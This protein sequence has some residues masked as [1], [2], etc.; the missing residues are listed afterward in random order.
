M[1]M[2]NKVYQ[3]IFNEFA[4]YLPNDWQ[5]MVVYLEYGDDSYTFSFYVLIDGKFI[6]CYDIPGISEE[7]LIISYNKIDKMIPQIRNKEFGEWS[8]MTMVVDKEGN[9]K[10]DFDYTD[11][12]EGAYQYKKEWKKKYLE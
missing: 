11:L 8:N 9:M 2:N 6:K 1:T 10:T 7:S 4:S 12:S 5:K 3:D